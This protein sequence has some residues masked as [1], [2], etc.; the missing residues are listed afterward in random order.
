MCERSISKEYQSG[1]AGTKRDLEKQ[2]SIRGASA[3]DSWAGWERAS[4]PLDFDPAR[5]PQ[6]PVLKASSAA[7]GT[8]QGDR[9]F[10][11]WIPLEGS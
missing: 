1:K 5:L 7:H 8:I 6:G 3:R 9:P 4:G 10:I 2:S 11:Q